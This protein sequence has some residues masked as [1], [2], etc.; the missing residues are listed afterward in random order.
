M[1]KG[2]V[3][4]ADEQLA[5]V[6]GGQASEYVKIFCYMFGQGKPLSD[7]CMEFLELVKEGS[8]HDCYVFLR[9]AEGTDP[10]LDEV[11]E[12]FF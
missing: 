3:E 12:K 10:L 7:K 8:D 11:F 4:L 5:Q 9:N 1:G 6:S 2:R